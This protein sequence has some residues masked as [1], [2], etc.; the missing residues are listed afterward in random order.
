MVWGR[1]EGKKGRIRIMGVELAGGD[2]YSSY[3]P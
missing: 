1:F 2:G 3:V